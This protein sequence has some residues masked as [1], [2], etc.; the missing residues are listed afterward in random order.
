MALGVIQVAD[1]LG[2]AI[3]EQ[4]SVLGFD[5]IEYAALP[6]IRL[7]TVSQ[8]TPLLARSAVRLLMELIESGEDAVYTRKLVTPSIIQRA[9]CRPLSPEEAPPA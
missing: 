3:P 7:T 2:L 6:N 5:N 8:N 9:T 1:E 4:L